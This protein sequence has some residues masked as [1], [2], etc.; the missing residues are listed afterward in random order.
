MAMINV[1]QFGGVSPRTPPRY[2]A[3]FQAQQALN[4]P[5]WLGSLS[6]L[7][8]V[9]KVKDT[10]KTAV[11][12]I[13]RFGQDINEDGRYW[14][15]FTRDTDVVRGAIAGD[16]EERTYFTDGV[17]P[18]KTNNVLALTG[19]TS[20]PV[21]A[22]DLGVPRP[23][24]PCTAVVS[25]AGTGTPESRVYTYTFK[26]SWHEESQ[27][28]DPSPSVDVMVG[29]AVSLGML[30]VPPTGNFD[31]ATK[32]I[33]RL[34]VGNSTS[35]YLFVDEIP[36]SATTF[37]D[38]TLAQDL[39]EPCPS[40]NYAVPPD[41]L[42]GLVSLPNGGMAAHSGID[43]Y[44]AEPYRPYAWP[45]SYIQSVDYP[46]VGLGVMDTTIAV[47]TTGVPYLAQGSSPDQIV[48]TKSSIQQSCVSKRS[49][50]TMGQAV[51]YASPD[52]LVTISSA[53][54]GLITESMYS[55]EQWQALN[56]AT[57]HAYLW[58]NKYVAFFDAGGGFVFDPTSKTFIPHSVNAQAGYLDPQRDALYL[59]SGNELLTWYSGA[60]MDYIW[61]SKKFT[62]PA[63]MFFSRAVVRAESYP[64]TFRLYQDG[65]LTHTEI[66]TSRKAF[67]LPAGLYEDVE[68]E[69]AGNTEVFWVV[70]AQ[71][72]D[73]L[74]KAEFANHG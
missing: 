74:T 43:L 59:V 29:Q 58:E 5:A 16:T 52:G 44:F 70:I 60:A 51:Y 67:T 14:F 28:A 12:S 31:I 37:T 68:F 20:Y 54:S 22:Y 42:T 25:G 71:S 47:L 10:V 64:V 36:A 41:T 2:L 57:I 56:P 62:A 65:V 9:T 4:C 1:K 38:T 35:E 50:V 72:I 45:A 66:A 63:P 21:A 11:L 13:Y 55:R 33:Y 30:E 24:T 8:G 34:V 53:G 18:K 19:G 17:K 61:R 49:I 73:E 3:D 26:T 15:E 27:P 7:P 32:C 23:S 40:I 39:G 6:G 46:I 48:M 69:I